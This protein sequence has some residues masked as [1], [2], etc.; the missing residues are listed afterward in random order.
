MLKCIAIGFGTFVAIIV[1]IVGALFFKP[2]WHTIPQ[3]GDTPIET[4]RAD[5]LS[6]V[7]RPGFFKYIDAEYDGFEPV[8]DIGYTDTATH[9]SQTFYVTKSGRKIARIFGMLICD[10]SFEMSRDQTFIP[11]PP[12]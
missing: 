7:S 8:E 2:L 6:I 12:K 4:V 10:G 11:E 5:I 3:C 9:W 1:I